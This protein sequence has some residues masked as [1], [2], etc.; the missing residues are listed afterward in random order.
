M[1]RWLRLAALLYPRAW[2]ERYGEELGALVEDADPR[3]SDLFDILRG[4][5]VMQIRTLWSFWKIAVA[6]AIAGLIV[7]YGWSWVMPKQYQSAVLLRFQEESDT[8]FAVD[9]VTR[10]WQDAT[11]R[12]SLS[13]MIQR[14]QL[15]LYH[16]LR[17]RM[18]MEDVIEHMRH[19]LS[20]DVTQTGSA[21]QFRIAFIYPDA[22]KAKAVVD[23]LT[24]KMGPNSQRIQ[25]VT[26]ARPPQG[27]AFASW[28]LG[29]GLAAGV[30]TV[31]LRWRARWTLKI[32]GFGM[33]VSA[34][35]G[36]LSFLLPTWYTSTAVVRLAPLSGSDRPTRLMSDSEMRAWL[37]KE[38][39]DVL[40]DARLAELI[41]RP[42]L[43]LYRSERKHRTLGEVVP[44]LRRDLRIEPISPGALRISF[45]YPDRFKAQMTAMAIVTNLIQSTYG[46]L[47]PASV[48]VQASNTYL[49]VD[50]QALEFFKCIQS[51]PQPLPAGA[52][53]RT[54]YV[55]LLDAASLPESPTA[56]NRWTIAIAGMA[57]GLL[58]GAYRNRSLISA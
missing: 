50:K 33:A 31:L 29:V 13:Q 18:P 14:P 10:K 43:D 53:Q 28:G 26:T 44:L 1:K 48:P 4:A 38:Q 36:G 17:R 57:A 32:I 42:A 3:W 34:T 8:L 49:C 47:P 16:D 21:R 11:T 45:R 30:L 20:I 46:G 35:I 54:E 27:W 25:V 52:R 7:G 12:R 6:V 2:R 19:E 56:P 23:E 40:D 51:L 15:D 37:R 9:E 39:V 58:V 5:S 55:A 24:S 41:Q 22:G